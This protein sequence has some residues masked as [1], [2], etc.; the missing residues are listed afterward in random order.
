M[1]RVK[2][3]ESIGTEIRIVRLAF[4]GI[5]KFMSIFAQIRNIQYSLVVHRELRP[6]AAGLTLA[7]AFAYCG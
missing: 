7:E 1:L 4:A 2:R 5:R 3:L 6:S